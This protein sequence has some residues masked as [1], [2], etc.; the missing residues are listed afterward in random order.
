MTRRKIDISRK[1]K[2][3]SGVEVKA[4]RRY[5]LFSALATYK[6]DPYSQV[7]QFIA[8]EHNGFPSYRDIRAKFH[9]QL[10]KIPLEKAMLEIDQKMKSLIVNS[11]SEFKCQQDFLDFIKAR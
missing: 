4:P 1:A 9:A 11:F 5:F 10:T 3:V 2:R 6:N 8:F 7:A